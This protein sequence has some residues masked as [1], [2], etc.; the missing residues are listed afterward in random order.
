MVEGGVE[1]WSALHLE[2]TLGSSAAT[3]GLALALFSGAMVT[4]RLS[5]QALG[6][7]F[8]ERTLL[9]CGG[10]LAAGG[11]T[12]AALAPG[13]AVA[14]A[15]L[16]ATGLGASVTMPAVLTITGRTVTAR[17]GAAVSTVTTVAYLGFLVGPP[18]VGLVAGVTSLRGGLLVLA[19]AAA[20]LAL[21][22]LVFAPRTERVVRDPA[23]ARARQRA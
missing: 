17:R 18:V 8:E 7:R 6:A 11:L 5:A 22:A 13:V 15:G 3:A 9:V 4:G 20:A 12:V 2:E 19:G 23:A 14:L 16:V 21:G 10:T 1:A